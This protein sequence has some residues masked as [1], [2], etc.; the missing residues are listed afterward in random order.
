MGNIFKKDVWLHP[1]VM[2]AFAIA[3]VIGIGS[4]AY[5]KIGSK[6]PQ[7]VLS[8][9]AASTTASAITAT[10]VVTTA[11]SPD[12]SFQS[13]GRVASV[14]VKVGSQVAKGAVLASLDTASL[15][16][17]R[18]QAAANL[19]AQEARLDDLKA[20]PRPV[21]ISQKQT[22]IAQAEQTL[23]DTYASTGNDIASSYSTLL[24]ALHAD[25]DPLYSNA[26]GASPTLIFYTSNSQVTTDAVDGRVEAGRET[27]TWG[28]EVSES[29]SGA[30]ATEAELSQ[31]L[32][33]A[34]A[35]RSYSDVMTQTL[36]VALTNSTSFTSTQLSLA[37]TSLSG[38]RSAIQGAIATMQADQQAIA[39]DKLAIQSAKDALAAAQAGSTEQEIEAQAASVDAANATLEAANV[40]LRNAII[41]APYSGTVTAVPVKVG[42]TV[43]ASTVAISLSPH[44][45]LQLDAYLS[46]ID[47]AHV[48]IGDNASV[49]LDA[50][51]TSRTFAAT[52]VSV[53]RSPTV[54]NG[55][56]AHKVVVQFTTDDPTLS[57]GMTGN[58]SITALN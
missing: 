56:P 2:T 27:A 46:E 14:A 55:V 12:L 11:E 58:V 51:G 5:Y 39:K 33:H 52:V 4:F 19:R 45:A 20:G 57:P 28:T 13:S 50:Y 16:A 15:A 43:S 23:S 32:A 8:T 1:V 22:A 53:D 48:Q 10:G 3:I 18:D 37:Q 47:A 29:D 17:V 7:M 44:S 35:L 6:A 41:V 9:P 24:G 21:D 38:F 49:T 25:I 36:G 30:D 54:Q 40:A 42:D 26:N 34:L 31:A